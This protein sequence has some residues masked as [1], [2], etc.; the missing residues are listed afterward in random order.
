MVSAIFVVN[1]L[2]NPNKVYGDTTIQPNYAPMND[3]GVLCGNGSSTLMLATS[4][5]RSFLRIS[6]ISQGNIYYGF[7]QPAATSTGGVLFASS[8]ME[9]NQ[10]NM[11]SGAIYCLATTA[12]ATTTIAEEK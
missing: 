4:T 11:Y 1:S 3:T 2:K 10:S 5:S 9:F 8:S 7:G 12:N 6:N